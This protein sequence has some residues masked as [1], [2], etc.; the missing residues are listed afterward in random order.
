MITLFNLDGLVI[1]G[2]DDVEGLL[3]G[4]VEDAADVFA[5]YADG[6]ELDAA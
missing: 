2:V 6:E 1:D 5:Y 3:F 4:F